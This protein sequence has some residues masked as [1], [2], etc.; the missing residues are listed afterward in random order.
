ML[1]AERY[2]LLLNHY[3][4]PEMAEPREVEVALEELTKLSYSQHA[5]HV[6]S[7]H[8]TGADDQ[9][10]RLDGFQG[11]LAYFHPHRGLI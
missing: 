6:R 3:S 9:Q 1:T 11:Y 8:D 10:S 2:L 5:E 4:G 7:P